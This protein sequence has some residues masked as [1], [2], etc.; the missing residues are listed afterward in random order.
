M[1]LPLPFDGSPIH[2]CSVPTAAESA[3]LPWRNPGMPRSEYRN[4]RVD[5][6][7]LCR[8]RDDF[9][10]AR[11]ALGQDDSAIVPRSR[12][13]ALWFRRSPPR[14]IRA[15]SEAEGA[16]T[17][18]RISEASS[19]REGFEWFGNFTEDVVT[20]CQAVPELR[21]AGRDLS[22]GNVLLDEFQIALLARLQ[23]RVQLDRLV[24]F[25]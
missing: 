4:D 10:L 16:L 24:H 20:E 14:W 3:P 18:V 1:G 21:R 12:G 25:A 17:K 5:L 13:S 11:Y 9:R 22:S 19:L 6:P 8:Q 7:L 2:Q 15:R 23:F